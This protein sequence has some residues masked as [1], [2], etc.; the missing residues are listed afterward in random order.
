MGSSA[1]VQREFRIRNDDGNETTASW[2]TNANTDASLNVDTNY[3][4][5]ISIKAG[6]FGYTSQTFNLYYS[7]NGAAYAAIAAGQAVKYS[8]SGNVAQGDDTT[9]QLSTEALYTYTS[10]N[11]GICESGGCTNTGAATLTF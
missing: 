8:A 9:Q 6:I 5:R 3:R 1:Y 10:D 7:L 2:V 4:I 11:N